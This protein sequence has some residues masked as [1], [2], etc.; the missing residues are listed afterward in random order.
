MLYTREMK[1]KDNMS[2]NNQ[3]RAPSTVSL[4]ATI[5]VAILAVVVAGVAV[6]TGI[7]SGK[8]ESSDVSVSKPEPFRP[9]EQFVEDCTYAAH[10]LV[11]QHY[12]MLRLFVIDSLP[13]FDEPYGNEPEDG[14]YTVNSTAYTSL[15]DIE[16]RLNQTYTDETV[17]RIMNNLDGKGLKV[18][19]MRTVLED[20]EYDE[21]AEDDTSRPKYREAQVLGISSAFVPA[22]EKNDAWEECKISCNI[23]SETECELSI[24]LNG[25]SAETEGAKPLKTTMIKVGDNWKLTSFVY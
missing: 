10:D 22:P 17:D 6:V 14:L 25:Q 21:P 11:K 23:L 9:T 24:Y 18:Y 16:A 8:N 20:I 19:Q 12:E 1:G 5:I 7:N 3:N 4:I 2:Q 13:H 15:E